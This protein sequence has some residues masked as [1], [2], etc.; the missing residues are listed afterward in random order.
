MRVFCFAQS[1]NNPSPCTTVSYLSSIT[2]QLVPG[3]RMSY[4]LGTHVMNYLI[5]AA[6]VLL[7]LLMD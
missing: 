7:K 5:M 4:R 3:Y 2:T 6:L 1:D